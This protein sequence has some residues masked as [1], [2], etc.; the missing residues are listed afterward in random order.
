MSDR[1]DVTATNEVRAPTSAVSDDHD[2]VVLDERPDRDDRALVAE[3]QRGPRN[4]P[5]AHE[6]AATAPPRV[7]DLVEAAT[8]RARLGRVQTTA[9]TAVVD[10]V[11]PRVGDVPALAAPSATNDR[12]VLR[13]RERTVDPAT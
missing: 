11:F 8:R 6:R 12:G 5:N 2:Q 9:T 1:C 10:R 13:V 7:T 3:P 4:S